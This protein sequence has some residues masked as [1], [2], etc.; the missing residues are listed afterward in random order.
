MSDVYPH[1][2]SP[3]NLGF[4]TLKNRSIM[5]SMHVGLEEERGGFEKLA[6][7][8]AERARGGCALMVTGGVSPN[9]RG[10]LKP[11]GVRLTRKAHVRDHRLITDAVHADGGKI[12]LQIL[13]AGR[14]GYHPLCVAPSAIK[15]PISKFKPKALSKRQI[16]STISDFARC[17]RLAQ[18]AGYDGVEVM[19]S[20]GYLINQFIAP[21]T[22]H[23]RDE[24]G[25]ELENRVRF[26]LEIVRQIRREVGPNF[27]LIFRLSMLD[28]VEGGSEWSEVVYLAKELESAGVTLINTGIGWHEARVPTIATLVP[29]GGFSAVTRRLKAEV[30]IPVITSNRINTPEI[31]E[32]LLARGDADCVSMARPFLA[33]AD[34]MLKAQQGRADRIN[35]CIACNQACLDHAFKNKRASCLVN[36]RA[37]YETELQPKPAEVIKRVAVI[38]A[39]PAGLSAASTAAERGHRVTL[40][41]QHS[42]IGGQ[43]NLA[44]KIPGKEEF[45]ETL[46]YFK[47][48]L[49][50]AGVTLELGHRVEAKSLQ[51]LDFDEVILATGVHPRRVEITGSEH[52]KVLNYIQVLSG[53]ERVG[54]RVALIGAG[55][56][57]FD[58]AEFLLSK[59][60]E[61]A[62]QG[63]ASPPDLQEYLHE[64]G[65]D[66]QYKTGSGLIPPVNR[67]PGRKLYLLQ[68]SSGKLGAR[69]G[70]TTGWIHR[71]QLK[72]GAVEMLS[73]VEYERI[74]DR[75]I[76]IK[77][78]S[79]PRLLEVDHVIICAGQT[80]N[81]DL[82]QQLS[83]LG[84]NPIL[85]GGADE[86]SE[87]DAKRAIRQGFEIA[88]SI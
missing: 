88:L 62:L 22:N 72:R 10:W 2:F 74:D 29:R 41:D 1:L 13:H 24:W 53:Q 7:Y 25:G 70:K 79:K 14:Y 30:S 83:D 57:G 12:C 81:R 33:D 75:G 8:F 76:H 17:A 42:E 44:K 16:R 47:N 31:A 11:F 15:S 59:G 45:Y 18:E 77:I 5:G 51:D 37:C 39:G 58:V 46:R 43:F 49:L 40:F 65:V 32:D 20:E 38:G 28:L 4:T 9:V 27:I 78:E 69:L 3:L 48:R 52:S 87:L 50:D 23:R 85:I 68:R 21:R 56:I 36:P 54:D 6:T 60:D 67:T 66:P 84:M 80:P 64:W 19:G 35:T 61:S 55:G 26:P 82:S 86:A 71:A 63:E 73:G 34:F